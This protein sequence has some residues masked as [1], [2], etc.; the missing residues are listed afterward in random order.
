MGAPTIYLGVEIKNYQVGNGKEHYSMS[1][2]QYVKNGIKTV[3]QLFNDDGRQWRVTKT[4]G[5]QPLPSS[6]RPELEQS[7]ELGTELMSRYLQ[8]IGIL[9]WS[10]ELECIDIFCEVAMMSQ[11]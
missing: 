6:Y 4:S 11:Y 1:S 8:L 10:V 3:E 2:T 9:R 5:K 7:D